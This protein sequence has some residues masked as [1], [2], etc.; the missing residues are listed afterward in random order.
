MAPI[1]TRYQGDTSSPAPT[2]PHD[3]ESIARSVS[4]FKAKNKKG[5]KKGSGASS[6][7]E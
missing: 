1:L 2:D 3:A 5:G 4:V 7:S 6:G